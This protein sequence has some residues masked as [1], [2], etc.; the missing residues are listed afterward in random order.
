MA[1]LLTTR[2]FAHLIGI[3]RKS[4][5]RALAKCHSGGTYMGHPLRV[6]RRTGARGHGG[7]AY[8]VDRSSIPAGWLNGATATDVVSMAVAPAE[9]LSVTQSA[10]RAVASPIEFEWKCKLIERIVT[11][12]APRTPE[13]RDLI[14]QLAEV[15]RYPDGS[16][17]GQPLGRSTLYAWVLAY[18]RGGLLALGRRTRTDKRSRRVILS[19]QLDA[20]LAQLGMSR[21]E[22]AALA[23]EVRRFIQ[24][25]WAKAVPS[26]STI[27][28]NTI[29]FLKPKLQAMG[30]VLPEHELIRLCRLPRNVIE[31][32]RHFRAV[33]IYRTD[34][35]RSAAIQTPRITRDR[36]H[37]KPMEWVA[38]DVHPCDIIFTRADGSQCT[39]KAV[40]WMDLATNRL[41]VKV[42]VL[43]PRQGI[44]REHVIESFA[45]M[46]ADPAWGVPTRLYLDNGKEYVWTDAAADLL[47]LKHHV[48][49]KF[50]GAGTQDEAGVRRARPYNPQAKIIETAFATLERSFLSQLQGFIGGNRM[51][52]K[53]ENQGQ[54]PRSHGSDVTE[55][56]NSIAVAV[57]AYHAKPQSGDSHLGG[58]SPNDAF[59]GFVDGG[60]TSTTLDP[61]ELELAFSNVETRT[62]RAGGVISCGGREFRH[63]AIEYLAGIGKVLVRVPLF[64]NRDQVY[65]FNEDE[66]FIGRALPVDPYTFG[67]ISGAGE[68]QRQASVLRQ[69]IQ[70]LAADCD[71][72][73][74]PQRLMEAAAAA[75][76]SA[77]ESQSSNVV[78]LDLKMARAA[79]DIRTQAPPVTIDEAEHSQRKQYADLKRL[80]GLIRERTKD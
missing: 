67:D 51:K 77:P 48:E 19:R 9:P 50:T 72:T 4:A 71:M 27:Q 23:D 24:S 44:R 60:W 6:E 62:V 17:R 41:F 11:A 78:S 56:F 39:P 31:S 22:Q 47:R 32:S 63:D 15:E 57:D 16:K 73:I 59:R 8:L 52:K 55:L 40:V 80:T 64:G 37:L 34:A 69:Q 65:L 35:A 33:A 1:E 29:G 53:V 2:E 76:G 5:H 74:D 70:G 79:A 46:C 21:C 66:D 28:F 38:G 7:K 13:R 75:H 45:A 54:A 10:R 43:E 49:V 42:F 14:H 30:C 36:S 26:W 61:F 18:E 3:T 12:T 68:Q 20:Q 25:Q 58:Q